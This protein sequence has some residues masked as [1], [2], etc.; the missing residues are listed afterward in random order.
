[1]ERWAGFGF[2]AADLASVTHRKKKQ[3]TDGSLLH[4]E[5]PKPVRNSIRS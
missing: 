1:M 5:S 2:P 3:E 4:Y